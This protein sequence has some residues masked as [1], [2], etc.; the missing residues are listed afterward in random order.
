MGPKINDYVYCNIYGNISDSTACKWINTILT[1]TSYNGAS[2]QWMN[3]EYCE[4][5]MSMDVYFVYKHG[6]KLYLYIV[7]SSTYRWH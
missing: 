3:C 5:D 1:F 4:C 6:H 7:Y 2:L